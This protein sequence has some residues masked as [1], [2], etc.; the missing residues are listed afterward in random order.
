MTN[1]KKAVSLLSGGLD[2]ILA[3]KLILDQGIE[4]SAL[5]FTSPFCNCTHG[6]NKTCGIQAVRTAGELGVKVTVRT[7]D[8][9]YLKMVMAPRHGYGSNMN[10]CID[11]RIFMLQKTKEFM[12]EIGAAFVITGEVLGQRPMSQRRDAMRLIDR[13]S[14]LEGLIVRPL[15]A[16]HLPP[17]IPERMGVID[18]EKLLDLSGRSRKGQYR[19]AG[20]YNLKEFSCP[21][22]GCLLTDPIFA[23]KIRE[24]FEHNPDC[25]MRDALLL[26]IGR[27]FRLSKKVKLIVGR[28]KEEN[29]HLCS[30]RRDGDLFLQ[31]LSFVGPSGLLVGNADD[32]SVE[33]AANVMAAHA[34]R[35]E[36]PISV[37]LGDHASTRLAVDRCP[38]DLE[39]MRIG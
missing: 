5:H 1:I 26:K 8:Q 24:L 13:E 31:P 34:K 4:V 10:P 17:S 9:D 21:G 36:F 27:H 28:N 15:S 16:R 29:G 20:E 25:T 19:L 32:S 2:S 7:K 23:K 39:S 18:R 30:L 11:C 35:C 33:T 37:V 38:V 14:G 12:R 6:P 3:T 22:G